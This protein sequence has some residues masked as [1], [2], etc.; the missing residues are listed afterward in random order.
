MGGPGDYQARVTPAS[1]R[2]LLALFAM[3]ASLVPMPG[4]AQLRLPEPVGYVNDFADVISEADRARIQGVIDEVR[5]KSQGEIVVVTLPSLE[6]RPASEVALQ[7]GREWQIG[8]K[9]DLGDAARNS[10]VVV[11]VAPSE[12]EWRIETGLGTNTFI[13]AAEAG[14][15]GRD[16]MVP[17]F[18]NEQYGEGIYRGVVALA[19]EYAEQFNF[20]LTGVPPQQ[21]RPT[22]TR[23][24]G[25]PSFFTILLIIFIIMAIA[26]RR[27]G[28]GPRGGGGGRGGGRRS[29]VPII[30]PFPMG[31]RAEQS[32]KSRKV[33]R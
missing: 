13:T 11:L 3:I 22:S 29:G 17:A 28:G 20:E 21:P 7:I 32:R 33:D 19:R 24:G 18:R 8:A 27:G 16:E 1:R 14:R 31:G 23:D 10:G 12:R 9:G 26:G 2:F 4:M 30:V 5:A 25:G 15:I 6:N